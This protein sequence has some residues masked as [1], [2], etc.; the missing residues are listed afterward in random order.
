MQ[1]APPVTGGAPTPLAL[2]KPDGRSAPDRN[3]M[4]NTTA[5]PQPN[6]TP[7][8]TSVDKG[9]VRNGA[10]TLRRPILR[11]NGTSHSGLPVSV[12]GLS[13]QVRASC[14]VPSRP[15]SPCHTGPRAN[16]QGAFQ[17][18][19]PMSHG[20]QSQLRNN[21]RNILRANGWSSSSQKAFSGPRTPCTAS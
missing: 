9:G 6:P 5:R 10:A 12:T 14:N 11:N 20:A 7:K 8:C 1:R 17:A 18:L 19:V 16:S 15:W 2:Q 3:V 4:R 21:K 13:D